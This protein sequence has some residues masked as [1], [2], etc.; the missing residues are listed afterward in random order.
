MKR[1]QG[2]SYQEIASALEATVPAVESLL[3]RAAATLKREL[4]GK[5]DLS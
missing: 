1:Y 2:L 5:V 3:Q 4:S